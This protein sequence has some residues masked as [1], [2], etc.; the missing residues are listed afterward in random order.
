MVLSDVG[1]TSWLLGLF[2]GFFFLITCVKPEI[3]DNQRFTLMIESPRSFQQYCESSDISSFHIYQLVSAQ[4]CGGCCG[5]G[6]GVLSR[7]RAHFPVFL[8]R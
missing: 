6:G 5:G 2:Y 3:Y 1:P 4:H 7:K 8:G